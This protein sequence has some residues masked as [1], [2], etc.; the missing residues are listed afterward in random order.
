MPTME[1]EQLK[2]LHRI[3]EEARRILRETAY[4]EYKLKDKIN[5]RERYNADP[6]YRTHVKEVVKRH[7]D[8]KRAEYLAIKNVQNVESSPSAN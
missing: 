3:R 7:R 8:K 5:K 4:K 6:E 1:S 2:E